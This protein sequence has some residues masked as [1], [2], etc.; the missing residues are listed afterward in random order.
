[1]VAGDDALL[2]TVAKV[3]EQ[4]KQSSRALRAAV[5]TSL[6][7]LDD[8]RVADIVLASYTKQEP[9]VRPK[10]IELLTQRRSW[11][12]Q[13]LVAVGR[14]EIPTSALNVNQVRRILAGGD[15][16]MAKLVAKNWGILRNQRDAKR[17]IVV[18]RM[19]RF[20]RTHPG[21]AVRGIAVYKK[22][23]GQCH[24]LYGQGDEVGPDITTNGR[25]SFAQLLSNVFD[26]SLVI[27]AAYQARTVVTADGRILT[28]LPVED[29][30]QRVVLKMQG[31]KLE[32]IARAD[33]EQ[34]E[35]SKLSMMPEGV[36]KQLK[37]EELADLFAYLTLDR[38]PN[39]P[40]ARRLAGVYEIVPRET[41]NRAQF[42]AMLS[43]VA[44]GFTVAASGER[45]VGLLQ[46]HRGRSVVVRTHPVSPSRACVIRSKAAIPEGMTTKLQ[47]E[48]SH[49][50]QGDWRLVVKANGRVL[51]DSIIGKETTQ[52]GWKEVTVDLSDLAGR[53][54]LLEIEN[55]ANNWAWE[56]AYWRRIDVV[57]Q[58]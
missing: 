2:D 26:P 31:G 46:S 33:V 43:E 47:L 45:G 9:D 32:V 6:G 41:R 11:T 1:M 44:P 25:N 23:C 19:R 15:S 21:D 27:G 29:S 51:H 49:H 54:V 20:V 24:K 17:E 48:V 22:L 5:L 50:P 34:M 18:Q 38:P 14:K 39:D 28:G 3:L 40:S 56:F 57:S 30:P 53:E 52:D 58:E 7:R 42:N 12:R 10:A 35:V 16:E 55:A 8:P 36:E 13:L 4:P 37:P